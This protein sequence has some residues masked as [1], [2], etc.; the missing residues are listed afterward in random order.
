MNITFFGLRPITF[1][2][3]S[4]YRMKKLVL[5]GI[6]ALVVGLGAAYYLWNKPHRD[7]AS[8]DAAF[9]LTAD[10]LFDAFEA[11]ETAANA[12]YLDKVV[13]V[14]GQVAEVTVNDAGQSVLTI[15]AANAMLGGVSATMQNK[16]AV[17]V[18]EGDA[19][20]VKCRCTGYLMDVIL[21]NC[22]IQ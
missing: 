10:E 12:K 11:D 20:T 22:S 21:I 19:V 16:D 18:A 15:T 14:T 7:I 5:F 9:A 17:T 2:A 6:V 3:P 8:E 13:A 4:N 1:V